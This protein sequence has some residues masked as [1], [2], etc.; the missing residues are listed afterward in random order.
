MRDQKKIGVFI[1]QARV[2]QG[3][4]REALARVLH[5]S[6]ADIAAWEDGTGYPALSQAPALARELSVS[7]DELFNARYH[8]VAEEYQAPEALFLAAE[9]MP[10]EAAETGGPADKA[11]S[12]TPCMPSADEDAL[13]HPPRWAKALGIAGLCVE[14][15]ACGLLLLPAWPRAVTILLVCISLVAAA[16][17]SAA[18]AALFQKAEG[19][20]RRALLLFLLSA[21]LLP[22]ACFFRGIR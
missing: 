3:I 16:A 22:L 4:S 21:V 14:A 13:P 11:G 15:A 17:A 10:E 6:E 19:L 18:A 5:V 12:E 2:R 20:R 1:A 7:L 8:T 9:A